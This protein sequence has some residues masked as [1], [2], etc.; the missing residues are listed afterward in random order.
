LKLTKLSNHSYIP[1][2]GGS[3]VYR[4][5]NLV[6]IVLVSGISTGCDNEPFAV[7]APAFRDETGTALIS[8]QIPPFSR[9][10]IHR[11][12]ISVTATDTGRI[13]TIKRDMNFPIPGGN[14]AVSQ[15]ADIPPG[16]RRFFIAAFDT[17]DT[18]GVPRFQ[19]FADSTVV[20]GQTKLI[21]VKLNRVGGMVNFVALLDTADAGL[22]EQVFSL[23]PLSSVLDISELIPKPH[24]DALDILP[25]VSVGLGDSFTALAEGTF[26]R[27]VTVAQIPT[28]I[29]RFVA[30]LK[31]LSSNGTR[32]FTDTVI[33]EID[34]VNPKTATFNLRAV[35]R[36]ED[37]SKIF[38]QPTLPRDSTI[39]VLTPQF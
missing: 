36:A 25:L 8:V 17:A 18:R 12:S 13:R 31:D 24:H 28:G 5:L 27:R 21:T 26:S 39:V 14:L 4:L 19:G 11:V 23:L 38:R 2:T 34:T 3:S 9:G 22:S 7:V 15:V 6:L 10:L 30:H 29:R 1:I 37:L 35:E 20:P 32:A 33:T 16:R